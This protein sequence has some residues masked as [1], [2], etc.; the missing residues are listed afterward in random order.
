MLENDLQ[1]AAALLDCEIAAIK[2]VCKVESGRG[3]FL[4][5]GRP[6]V[7]FE[8]HIFSGLTNG[9]FDKTH[10][11]ISYPRWTKAYYS[12]N[13]DGEWARL[14]QAISLSAK[15]ALQS[16]SWGAFQL[17]GFNH[18]KC[19]FEDVGTFVEAMRESE[20]AQ[21]KAFVKFIKSTGLDAPLRDKN[22]A[23]FGRRYN[24]PGYSKNFYDQKLIMWYRIFKGKN[25]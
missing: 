21:L 5:D 9:A 6:T 17:M 1:E 23:E 3:G 18:V 12:K 10:P 14:S 8:G 15:A 4:P 19:G 20:R 24:G 25:A 16:T 2:A 13:G 7:L 11:T 22:W